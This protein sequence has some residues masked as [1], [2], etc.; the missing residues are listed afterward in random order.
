M[1]VS[2]FGRVL[3]SYFNRILV[4]LEASLWLV[5]MIDVG[6]YG[7][8]WNASLV[9]GHSFVCMAVCLFRVSTFTG[10][11]YYACGCEV[12]F[13]SSSS[14][15]HAYIHLP[16]SL[17]LI[18]LTD[19]VCNTDQG[20]HFKIIYKHTGSTVGWNLTWQSDQ[21]DKLNN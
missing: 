17:P 11:Q 15:N 14:P 18:A 9:D 10:V 2:C 4:C 5:P 21:I 16:S 1:N 3:V 12:A 19:N 13:L 8:D 7:R 6:V 20:P